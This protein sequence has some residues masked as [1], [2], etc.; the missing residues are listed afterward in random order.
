MRLHGRNAKEWWRHEKTEDRYNYLYS[1]EE[2][3]E[4]VDTAR[5]ARTLVKKMYLYTNNH[6]SAKSVANAAMIKKQLRV[7]LE[8]EYPEA[9]VEQFPDLADAVKV[10]N[11]NTALP[12]T[13]SRTSS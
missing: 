3:D 5:A 1:S 6:F 11:R 13:P 9:F 2:L 8:G 10:A 7:P 4:F 12:F